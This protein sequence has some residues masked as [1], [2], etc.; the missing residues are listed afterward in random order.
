MR[1]K[2]QTIIKILKNILKST[3]KTPST[4]T[5]RENINEFELKPISKAAKERR[6]KRRKYDE[7]TKIQRVEAKRIKNAKK[8][9][10]QKLELIKC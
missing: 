1:K 3:L 4:Y 9:K 2:M 7:K 6:I 8:K 5:D 10:S